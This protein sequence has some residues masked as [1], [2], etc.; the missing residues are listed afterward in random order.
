MNKISDFDR[1]LLTKQVEELFFFAPAAV[2]FSFIGA[3]AT[4]VVFH[5]TGALAKGLFW[6]LF[7]TLI[8]FFRTVVVLVYRQQTKPV[9][10]PGKWAQLMI[11]GN[12]LAGMQWAILGTVLFPADHN[13]REL[14]TILILA[15]YV[16]GSIAVYSPVKWAQMAFA[17]P[18][19]VP[20][21][22]YI[23]FMR[24]GVNWLGGS[25]AII[26]I[27]GVF[28]FS[29]RQHHN[30]GR[31]LKTELEN[32]DLLA[33]SRKTSTANGIAAPVSGSANGGTRISFLSIPT[34]HGPTTQ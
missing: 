10:D 1:R 11:A 8:M 13:Y 22:I 34:Y 28:Y 27:F 20:P 18:A 12:I 7:A 9:T 25:A 29:R 30:I 19:S 4:V 17:I 32:E 31:R 33:R 16:A 14:F 5:D 24:D 2:A 26:F 21:V 23:F 3:I 15:S 6:F